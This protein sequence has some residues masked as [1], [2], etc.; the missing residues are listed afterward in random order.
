MATANRRAFRLRACQTCRGDAY[1]DQS[2]TPEWR[3]LQCGRLVS[4]EAPV[5]AAMSRIDVRRAA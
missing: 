2:D 1:L 3:C 5:V 4:E